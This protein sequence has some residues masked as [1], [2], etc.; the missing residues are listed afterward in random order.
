MSEKIESVNKTFEKGTDH[1]EKNMKKVV[2]LGQKMK[3]IHAS[4]Q[5][6]RDAIEVI[7][8]DSEYISTMAEQV[9]LEAGR[10]SSQSEQI[11]EIDRCLSGYF[12][13]MIN[14]FGTGIH[15][16]NNKDFMSFLDKAVISH[17]NWLN[18]LEQMVKSQ[19][20]VPIQEDDKRC[21]FRRF[22]NV[23]TIENSSIKERWQAIDSIHKVLHK[24][25]HDVIEALKEN[26]MSQAEVLMFE[27]K[28]VSEEVFKSIEE[29]KQEVEKLT[30]RNEKVLSFYNL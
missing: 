1:V 12:E 10:N 8:G 5:E 20:I 6:L 29:M 13:E 14:K 30:K 27:T 16:I 2:E 11:R 22:Y 21:E 19:G 7:R 9:S 4:I 26:N 18:K 28:K 15:P 25:A 23:L 24:N 17:K 3:E